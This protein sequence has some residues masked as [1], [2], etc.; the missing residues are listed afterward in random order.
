MV[1]QA[2]D[3]MAWEAETWLSMRQASLVSM[4]RSRPAKAE[5]LRPCLNKMGAFHT[6]IYIQIPIRCCGWQVI[7]GM[8]SLATSVL[9]L[10]TSEQV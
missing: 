3:A 6:Y 8:V 5:Q 7:T 2:S 9:L 1:V 4:V 10:R